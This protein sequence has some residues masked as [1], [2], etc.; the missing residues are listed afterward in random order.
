MLSG[1]SQV[2]DAWYVLSSYRRQA[3][4]WTFQELQPS[5][6]LDP[7]EKVPSLHLFL[8]HTTQY[9]CQEIHGVAHTLRV[10]LP[11]T[12]LIVKMRRKGEETQDEWMDNKKKKR[13]RARNYS[14][15]TKTH[16]HWLLRP[17][18]WISDAQGTLYTHKYA[19]THTCRLTHMHT[20]THT[21]AH[22]LQPL[23]LGGHWSHLSST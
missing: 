8:S 4:A 22:T 12:N 20:C 18:V 10:L 17:P 21:Y 7:N 23:R 1:A 13:E 16:Q 15:G 11:P 19:C 2:R 14:V 3:V 9:V 5:T 6:L